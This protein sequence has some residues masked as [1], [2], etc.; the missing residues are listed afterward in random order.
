[1]SPRA[2][3]ARNSIARR[4]LLAAACAIG[5][6]GMG[7]PAF[8]QEWPTKPV[9]IV[10]P[11]PP[12]GNTDTMARLAA[13]Y[14]SRT[15]GQNFIVENRSTAGGVVASQQVARSE[16]DGSTLFFASA[17]QLIIQPT[18]Q[19]VN[20]DPE[21]DFIPVSIF[22]TGPF[23]LGVRSSLPVKT[24]QELVTYAKGRKQALNVASPGIGSIGHLSA[25]LFAKRAGLEFVFVPY[26]GGGPAMQALLSHETDMYFGN[27]SEL[28]QHKDGGRIR[29]LA[30]SVEKPLD[31]IPEVPPVGSMLPGFK[32]SSW[33]GFFVPAGT[34]PAIVAKLEGAVIAAMKDPKISARL[35]QLGIAPGGTTSKEFAAIIAAD[36][37]LYREAIQAAGIKLP[38]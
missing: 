8:A 17:G 36:R 18:I 9:T 20:Y 28:I 21:K 16:P 31:Q 15:M 13:D 1:V 22:G 30:V 3:S 10:V 19:K 23:I 32:T 12:G 34:P 33:N 25:A 7:I 2:T 29:L 11:F 4:A 37:P 24:M 6:L 38:H 35:K 14:F 26:K 5:V 27:G